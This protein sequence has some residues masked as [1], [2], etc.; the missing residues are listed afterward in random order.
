MAPNKF[1]KKMDLG[2]EFPPVLVLFWGL[3]D[4]GAQD[5]P[6]PDFY[7]LLINFGSVLEGS[8]APRSFQNLDFGGVLGP[9]ILQEPRCSEVLGPSPKVLFPSPVGACLAKPLGIDLI[10]C[11]YDYK[12]I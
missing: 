2:W 12:D 4:L 8:W 11:E 6:R 5:P 9:K 10:S 7:Q 1:P 3:G